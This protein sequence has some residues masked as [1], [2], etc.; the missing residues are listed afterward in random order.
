MRQDL[1]HPSVT[2]GNKQ[3][4]NKDT[5][6]SFWKNVGKVAATVGKGALDVASDTLEK[7]REY[8]QEMAGKS[9]SQLLDILRTQSMSLR[10]GAAATELKNRGYTQDEINSA[11][12]S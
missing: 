7:S 4:K 3:L 12:R 8:K 1:P 5:F 10:V 11:R 9:D 2:Y 6:M